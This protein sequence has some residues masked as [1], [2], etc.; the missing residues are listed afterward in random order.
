MT[1]SSTTASSTSGPRAAA[2]P[3]RPVKLVCQQLWKVFGAPADRLAKDKRAF[4]GTREAVL[5]DLPS[6][7]GM[8]AVIDASFEV[9]T[10]E[11]F[12]IMGLS[13][14]G[15]STMVRCLSRL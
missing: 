4:S 12:V 15:K 10:G 9:G 5:A 3:E 8:P 7:G 2:L 13:G 11:I 6:R 1:T 14:S